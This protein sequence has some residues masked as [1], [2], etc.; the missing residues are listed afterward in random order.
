MPAFVHP[1]PPLFPITVTPPPGPR[2]A[3]FAQARRID[4]WGPRAW[5]EVMGSWELDGCQVSFSEQEAREADDEDVTIVLAVTDHGLGTAADR[6]TTCDWVLRRCWQILL[7]AP[8]IQVRTHLPGAAIRATNACWF[9]EPSAGAQAALCVRLEAVLPLAG[10]CCDGRRL[11][12][13][14]KQLEIFAADLRARRR[15]PDLAAHRH[16]VELQHALRAALPAL[17]LV[18]FLGEG[19]LL[20]RDA[21]DRPAAHCRPLHIP[22]AARVTIDLGA[23]GRQ[24]GLGIRTGITAVA[25]APY[26]GKSTLL[27]AIAAG[28]VDHP[29]GDGRE[30]VVADA[31][32]L[33][34]QAEDGRRI[35]NQDLS[36]FFAQ[37]PGADSARFAT[38]RASGAT[39][40][41]ASVLQGVAAGCRLLLVDEDSAASNFLSVDA[42]MRRLLGPALRGTTTLLEVLPALAAQG[43]STVLVAGSHLAS[44]A[45]ARRVL[46]MDHFQPRDATRRAAAALRAGGLDAPARAGAVALRVPERRFADGADCLL[47]PRHF[48]VL[49]AREPERPVV[50]GQRLDLRR[51]G[52]ALDAD[53]ARGACVAAAWVCR[54]AARD[55]ITLSEAH[56]RWLAFVA[57]HGIRGCDP[58][59]TVL[60]ALPPWQ[61]VVSALERLER[62]L[63]VSG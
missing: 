28:A 32:L 3:L 20:A 41:A 6:T 13:F 27:H 57:N 31:S 18:A 25:G 15:R 2:R 34:V 22:R 17:G 39:S 62:P 10:M 1:Y 61:L 21:D 8:A 51:S 43:V 59:D 30:R 46:V 45:G 26:H 40:M 11:V 52:W 19:A 58:F 35:K 14:L 60:L 56:A 37:L 53:L 48:L 24:H 9:Q 33:A 12:R 23:L 5:R 63:L 49:D 4:G 54:L 55:G 50:D 38:T 42:G 7:G 16:A 44:L 36:A 29:P 47:G